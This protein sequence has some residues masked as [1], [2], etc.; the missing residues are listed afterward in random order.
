MTATTLPKGTIR[1]INQQECILT[2]QTA[3]GKNNGK[4][5]YVVHTISYTCPVNGSKP[6]PIYGKPQ[7]VRAELFNQPE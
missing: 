3:Y 5:Y 7:W 4:L 2:G 6:K 1:T